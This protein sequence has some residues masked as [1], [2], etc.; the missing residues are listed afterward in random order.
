MDGACNRFRH[1]EKSTIL[2]HLHCPSSQ[3]AQSDLS[4]S[5]SDIRVC[6]PCHMSSAL[7]QQG[8]LVESMGIHCTFAWVTSQVICIMQE[9]LKEL[10]FHK[11]KAHS[12]DLRI[13]MH[14]ARKN[15]N[16]SGEICEPISI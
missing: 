9:L 16:I 5:S 8:N 13:L 3:T 6:V 15:V 14:I 7:M 12:V 10:C 1:D 4:L 2:V 11:P